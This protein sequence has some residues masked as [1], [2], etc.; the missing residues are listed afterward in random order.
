MH[1]GLVGVVGGILAHAV[2]EIF[3]GPLEKNKWQKMD[4]YEK[5]S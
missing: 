3:G 4:D 1:L 5:K 2:V